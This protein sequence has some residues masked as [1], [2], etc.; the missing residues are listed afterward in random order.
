MSDSS[1]AKRIAEQLDENPA[2]KRPS[3]SS[4]DSSVESDLLIYTPA[5][6]LEEGLKA[7]GWTE[8][9]IDRVRKETNMERFRSHFGA[10]PD[11]LAHIWEDLQTTSLPEAN[12]NRHFTARKK[13]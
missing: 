7:L 4:S 1:S 2:A 12:I 13:K 3:L 11:V 5:E 6:M 9:E 8:T 10:D